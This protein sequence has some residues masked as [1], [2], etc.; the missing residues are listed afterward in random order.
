MFDTVDTMSDCLQIAAGCL[1]TLTI[2]PAAMKVR[3][4]RLTL[5]NS[6]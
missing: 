5:S 3:R 2:N 1:A 4:C 6:R